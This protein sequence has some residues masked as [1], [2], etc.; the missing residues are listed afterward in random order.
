[1]EEQPAHDLV[2]TKL[3]SGAA[4]NKLVSICEAQGGFR[5]PKPAKYSKIIEAEFAGIISEIDNRKIAQV[6]KLSGAPDAPE[7]GVDFF[8]RLQQKVER[9]QPLF[10]IHA[11]SPGELAYAFEYYQQNHQTIKFH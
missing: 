2:E 5:E 11:N 10:S 9:G 8:V 4:F 6:A 7:A 3:N 1:M